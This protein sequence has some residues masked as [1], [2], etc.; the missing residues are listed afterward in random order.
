[1]TQVL[2]GSLVRTLDVA[3]DNKAFLYNISEIKLGHGYHRALFYVS[4]DIFP[5]VQWNEKARQMNGRRKVFFT[6]FVI[7]IAFHL[8]L[9]AAWSAHRLYTVQ[10]LADVKPQIFRV[11]NI[12]PLPT[13][14]EPARAINVPLRA[15]LSTPDKTRP[16]LPAASKLA[17][18]QNPAAPTPIIQA[19]S[20]RPTTSEDPANM[21]MG[22]FQSKIDPKKAWINVAESVNY[23]L[24]RGISIDISQGE[25]RLPD[26]LDIRVR[27][28][29]DLTVEY[30]LIAAAMGKE[31]VV[32]VLLLIDEQGQKTRVQVI[33]GSP[34]F[35]NAVLQ[36][37][38]KIEFRPAILKHVAVRSL[39]ILEFEFRRDPPEVGSL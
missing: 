7:S 27:A 9:G 15:A 20:E 23:D 35:D 16:S 26:E 32:Y 39:L 34:D 6:M 36:S 31:A 11:V 28:K 18:S 37:L 22:P 13:R 25:Y 12:A 30:P 21:P 38:E 14:A 10:N 3:G 17:L 1:M 29:G 33:R 2:R 8:L 4:F 5:I 24:L 19:Q